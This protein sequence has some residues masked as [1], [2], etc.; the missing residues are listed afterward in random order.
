MNNLK[1]NFVNGLAVT[2]VTAALLMVPIMVANTLS[3]P[4]VHHGTVATI[5]TLDTSAQS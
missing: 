2:A 3:A 1:L 4:E 5:Q